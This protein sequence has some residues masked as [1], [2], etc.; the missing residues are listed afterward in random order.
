MPCR[1]RKAHRREDE[2]NT[3]LTMRTRLPTFSPPPV[4]TDSS[5]SAVRR[6]AGTV[7]CA[8][9]AVLSTASHAESVTSTSRAQAGL[10]FRIVIPPIVRV[11]PVAQPTEITIEPGHVAQ[12][13]VDLEGASVVVLT[14]N[15]REGYQVAARYDTS[16]L[17]HVD[18]RVANQNI[19]VASG[20]G[21]ARVRSPLMT[22]AEVAVGYRLYLNPEVVAGKYAWPVALAFSTLSV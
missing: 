3:R 21:S 9:C 16:L 7:L 22:N 11:K 10:N 12:G 19:R 1:L 17:A 5:E 15:S 18:V 13:Y 20:Y 8:A 4:S 6:L 2:L 14:S